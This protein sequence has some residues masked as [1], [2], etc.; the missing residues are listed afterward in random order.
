LAPYSDAGRFEVIVAHPFESE[1]RRVL[2]Y[3]PDGVVPTE[4]HGRDLDKATR[5]GCAANI[6]LDGVTIALVATQDPFNHL[7][8]VEPTPLTRGLLYHPPPIEGVPGC[9][10]CRLIVRGQREGE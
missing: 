3:L 10:L 9:A 2:L 7:H 5:K 8:L 1:R 6:L 4:Q